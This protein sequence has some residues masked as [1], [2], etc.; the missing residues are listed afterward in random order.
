MLHHGF[1]LCLWGRDCYGNDNVVIYLWALHTLSNED[2][3]LRD[4]LNR[5][6]AISNHK[7]YR[8]ITRFTLSESFNKYQLRFD[9]KIMLQ[10]RCQILRRIRHFPVPNAQGVRV[11][12]SWSSLSYL[13]EKSYINI[14][15]Y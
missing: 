12:C 13:K 7:G 6:G 14:Y 4:F 10:H 8:L 5:E 2:I 3:S 9:P 1:K 15:D 11:S